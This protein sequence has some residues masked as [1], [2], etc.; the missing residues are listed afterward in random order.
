M[1]SAKAV[2]QTTA[3]AAL[4]FAKAA[5]EASMTVDDGEN[6]TPNSV[7]VVQTP[8]VTTVAGVP[9]IHVAI[10]MAKTYRYVTATPTGVTRSRLKT[11]AMTNARSALNVTFD[12][13]PKDLPDVGKT[14]LDL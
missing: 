6:T 12:H 8:A 3:I 14:M 11:A 13:R 1:R 7:M 10:K 5:V 9:G 4:R 2:I